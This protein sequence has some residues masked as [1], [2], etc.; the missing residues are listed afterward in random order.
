MRLVSFIAVLLILLLVSCGPA[1]Q[2][3]TPA[4][5]TALPAA[6][7]AAPAQAA[8]EPLPP[9]PTPVETKPTPTASKELQALLAKA[10]QKIKS[11]SYL[12]LIIPTKQQPDRFYVKGT[13]VKIKLYEYDPYVPDNYFDTVYLDT[14]SKT[15]IGRCENKRRCIWPQGDNTK[16]TWT[17]LDYNKYLTK[18]PYEFVKSVPPTATIIG[19]EVY[20]QRTVTKIEY[21]EG[22]KLVQ[23]WIDDTYGIPR[24]VR[25][26]PSSGEEL[27]YKFNDLQF[28]TLTDK[29]VTPP[30]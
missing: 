12:E 3:A 23:M 2:P 1:T 18:T 15:A 30:T 9:G 16:K 10:D 13:K 19:P 22:G 24:A 6:Q 8:P 14:V 5:Q 11:Y 20:D 29:D 17:E 4:Q 21:E 28:N 25:I 27:N 7:P 26:V